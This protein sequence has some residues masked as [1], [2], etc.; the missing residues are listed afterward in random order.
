[1]SLKNQ[2]CP[3]FSRSIPGIVHQVPISPHDLFGLT[4]SRF[5]KRVHE[6]PRKGRKALIDAVSK[7]HQCSAH[8]AGSAH[9]CAHEYLR[10]HFILRQ[11]LASRLMW[12]VVAHAVRDVSEAGH[13]GSLFCCG[14]SAGGKSFLKA[15][16]RLPGVVPVIKTGDGPSKAISRAGVK[17]LSAGQNRSTGVC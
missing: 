6:P 7:D 1:M 13:I 8:E 12:R 11:H 17:F 15:S 9:I 5:P 14:Y 3:A 10:R 4:L 16:R 2:T